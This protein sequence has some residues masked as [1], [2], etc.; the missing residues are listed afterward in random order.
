MLWPIPKST[1]YRISSEFNNDRGDHYH[2]G[3]D[4][5]CDKGT[6]IYAV[7]SG[8]VTL[9]KSTGSYG[10]HI[11]IDHGNNIV[12]LYAHCSAMYVSVG[13]KV[14]K[15]EHIAAVGNTGRSTGDHLHIEVRI[16]GKV[17]DP[18]KYLDK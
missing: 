4:I 16:N 7:M 13:D 17:Y 1:Y 14:S 11:M 5:A 18:M 15:G 2:K 12:T 9:V 3:V 10:K 6:P 8:T